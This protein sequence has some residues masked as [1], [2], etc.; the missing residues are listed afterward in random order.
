M[1]GS[2]ARRQRRPLWAWLAFAMVVAV[3]V[4]L[5]N[6]SRGRSAAIAEAEIDAKLTAQT[7]LATLLEPRDLET[8]VTGERAVELSTAIGSQITSVSR[9]D[10]VRIYSSVGR[11]LYAD[12]PSI[13]GT[14]PSYLRELTFEVANGDPESHARGGMLQTFVPIWLAPDGVV[15]VAEMSQPLDPVTSTAS[16]PWNTVALACGGFLLGAIAMIVV[17]SVA[18][19]ATLPGPVYDY[20]SRSGSR[21]Q[22]T[23][24]GT[25]PARIQQPG[26]REIQELHHMAEGRARAAE[27]DLRSVRTQLKDAMAQVSEL[28]LVI[29]TPSTGQQECEGLRERFRETSE[30]LNLIEMDNT[31][32]RERLHLREQELEEARSQIR[33]AGSAPAGMAELKQ[34]LEGAEVRASDMAREMK[35]IETELDDTTT[36]LH[37]SKLSE[38]LREIDNDDIESEEPSHAARVVVE[39]QPGITT[40]EKVR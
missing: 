22:P 5:F 32:L 9:I 39:H 21:A 33:A 40:P 38:A 8:P 16:G 6:A 1:L 35:R 7:E 2:L 26:V 4:S 13:V 36:R 17:T 14:R 30:R 25:A 37:M 15:V 19:S 23:G 12:D 27:Q 28:E 20:G 24:A 18:R 10:E 34:R 11:I 31:A 3:A 29:A